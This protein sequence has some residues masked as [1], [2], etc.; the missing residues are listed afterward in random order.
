MMASE[1]VYKPLLFDGAF[2]QL[3]GANWYSGGDQQLVQTTAVQLRDGRYPRES[4]EE[5]I[6]N[7]RVPDQ[8]RGA[9]QRN[10]RKVKG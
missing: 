8:L 1:F 4:D 3:L 2:F 7:S 9:G 6:P 10:S 5:T